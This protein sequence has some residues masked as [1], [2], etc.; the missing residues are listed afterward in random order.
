MDNTEQQNVITTNSQVM[1]LQQ[2]IAGPLVSTIEADALSSRRYYD[3]LQL[4][5]SIWKRMLVATAPRSSAFRWLRFCRCR[6]FRSRRPTSILTST[7]LMRFQRV[8]MIR[9]ITERDELTGVLLLPARSGY[10]RLWRP[11]VAPA[12][13]QGKASSSCLPI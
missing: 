11:R 1:E 10:V 4:I 5:A 3:M 2:L 9:L 8:A 7:F 13:I 6:C 12:P